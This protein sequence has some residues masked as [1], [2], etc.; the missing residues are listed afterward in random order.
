MKRL[1]ALLGATAALALGASAPVAAAPHLAAR[2][3]GHA[4][5]VDTE[6]VQA[7]ADA[8]GNVD[9]QRVYEQLVLRGSGTV[10]VTNP[11][12]TKG[13]RNL[14]GFGGFAVRDGNQIATY[15]LDKAGGTV[16][17]RTVSDHT[18]KMPLKVSVRYLL[19]GKEVQ[20]GDVVGASGHLEVEYTVEN[21]TARTQSV[22]IPDGK[23]GTTTRD[24]PVAVPFAGSLETTLPEQFS[25]VTSERANLAG[26]GHG[27]TKVNFTLTLFPPIGSTTT[28]LRWEADVTDGVVPDA[29][30]I[31]LP[32]N[33]METTPFATAA[34]GYAD[35][36]KRGN[37][38]G[39][40]AREMDANLLKLRD[41]AQDLLGGL[42]QLHDG[43]DTL[44][45]GLKNDALPGA[46]KL[47]D[48]SAALDAGL[49]KIDSG[50]G[51]L[52]AGATKLSNGTHDAA[53]GSTDLRNGLARISDGL[54]KLADVDGLP[55]AAEGAKALK[56]GVDQVLAGFGAVGQ[57]GT[58]LDGLSRLETG[59]GQLA[60]GL[61]Q[62]N[63]GLGQ[64]KGGV[65]QSKGGVDQVR[66]GLSS[67]V[68]AGGSIDQL[69][70]GLQALLGLDCGPICQ[71]VVT[72]KLVPSVQQSKTQLTAARDGLGQ[73]STGLGQ[74]S[75]GLGQAIGG[76]QTQLIPGAQQAA[77]GA[78]KANAGAKQLAGGITAIRAG[79]VDLESGLTDAVAGV[80]ALDDGAGTAYAGAGKLSAG[81]GLLDDG[82]GT[83]ASKTGELAAGAGEAHAG[84]TKVAGGNKELA[85]GLS[86]AADGSGQ[87]ADGMAKAAGGA[88]QIV[89][90]AGRLST[91]GAKVIAG[92]G[93]QAAQDYGELVAVMKAGGARADAEKMAYGAPKGAVGLTAYDVILQGEDG[94]SAR[95]LTRGLIGG[96]L[97]AATAGTVLLRRRL[98]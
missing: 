87:L 26:D 11:V 21:T 12:S 1:T 73:V 71:G 7:Y 79:L 9:T 72:T 76:L 22:Q 94:A 31:A 6:T 25:D 16:R 67:A 39:A 60:G 98:V 80:L 53:K 57:T 66:A 56:A 44:S 8:T 54:G 93:E 20:P 28:Q 74:V 68:D 83:L 34:D 2:D 82:A 32:V 69:L 70:G 15:D 38:L 49:A 43:A 88:P 18:A 85:D 51:R 45:A 63:G 64:A 89:D 24:V 78:T 58:L 96:G 77:D 42:V 46:R 37:E 5:I 92:K 84:S 10:T 91:E 52:A 86:E 47:A 13:L 95:N 62:L 75:G 36:A 33:P 61:Q 17:E 90:G 19:D 3:S 41:G 59:L 97:L 55:A 23:G 65:D 14:D 50:S 81:L 35:G 40:G 48:G 29:E 30:L 4:D 27:G